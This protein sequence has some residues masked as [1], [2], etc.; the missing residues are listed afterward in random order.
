VSDAVTAL[1][2]VGRSDGTHEATAADEGA[3][4]VALRLVDETSPRSLALVD[5]APHVYLVAQRKARVLPTRLLR[6]W[7]AELRRRVNRW[8]GSGK[9]S[10]CD[11]V[12]LYAVRHVLEDLGET[13]A[14]V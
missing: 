3:A 9:Y 13:L 4:V 7:E 11:W 12:R 10:H 6:L 5:D 2:P 14:E 1:L 8:R